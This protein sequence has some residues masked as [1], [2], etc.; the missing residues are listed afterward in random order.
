MLP[1]TDVGWE[2]KIVALRSA[3][4]HDRRVRV[5][6]AGAVTVLVRYSRSGTAA[7]EMTLPRRAA[8]V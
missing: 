3:A 2:K 7:G 1:K 8:P 4:R 5:H 6:R